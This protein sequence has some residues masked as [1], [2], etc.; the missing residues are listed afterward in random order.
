MRVILVYLGK[1]QEDGY[2]EQRE[3]EPRDQGISGDVKCFESMRIENGLKDLLG[4]TIEL[5]DVG[6]DSLLQVNAVRQ[7]LGRRESHSEEPGCSSIDANR[8][9]CFEAPGEIVLTEMEKMFGCLFA[10]EKN[11][12]YEKSQRH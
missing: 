11:T 1:Y 8:W 3:G 5:W 6:P 10:A 7:A 4:K 12:K 9:T 2:Q